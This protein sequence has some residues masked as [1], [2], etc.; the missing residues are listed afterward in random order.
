MPYV[1]MGGEWLSDSKLIIDKLERMSAEPL[2]SH[3]KPEDRAKIPAYRALCEDRLGGI[4]IHFRWYE[5]D[6]WDQFSRILFQKAP[7]MVRVLIG[8]RLRK[9]TKKR[10][11]SNGISRHSREEITQFAREDV[12][13]LAALL[14]EKNF[15]FGDR[16][17]TLDLSLFGILG[18]AL[19]GGID[20]PLVEIVKSHPN[21]VQ[22]IDRV[23]HL[24]YG[25]SLTKV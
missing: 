1:E 7:A 12:A 18:N 16:I 2:N 25:R 5:D 11:F 23:M 20:I 14:G 3:L 22:H 4:L 9:G 17:S 24:A 15:V 10:L 13:S 6:G 8:G 19:Y 21:L